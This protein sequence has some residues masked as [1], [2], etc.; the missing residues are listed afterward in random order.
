M[1]ELNGRVCLVTGASGVLGAAICEELVR[2]GAFVVG[3][4][5]RN[6]E[7]MHALVAETEALPGTLT[8][9]ACDLTSPEATTQMLATLTE[10]GRP[11]D[12]LICCAAKMLRKSALLTNQADCDQ[13]FDLNFDATARLVRQVLRPMLRQRV[14]RVVL[15]GSR[16][17]EHG[18]P[19][20]SVYAASKAALHG[21]AKSLAFEVGE[22][23]ITVNVVSPGAVAGPQTHYSEAD[24]QEVC[25]NIGLR[26]LGRPDEIAPIVS[27]LASARASYINGAIIA[28]DGG[29]RF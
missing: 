7:P 10:G 8:P 20:Q 3:L 28:V 29:G 6:I 1:L 26:R 17:G 9:L 15:I 11:I 16:A 21:F 18:M 23:G 25:R 4:Y 27:F 13:L 12:A 14:G 2:Q 22:Y 19:G 24:A 5:H